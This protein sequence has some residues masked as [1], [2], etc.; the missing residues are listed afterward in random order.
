M[1]FHAIENTLK[2]CTENNKVDQKAATINPSKML[3]NI[4]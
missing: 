1:N 3:D 2:K 4:I